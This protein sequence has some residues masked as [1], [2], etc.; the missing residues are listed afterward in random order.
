MGNTIFLDIETTGFKPEKGAE[1]L[2]FAG[3][4]CNTPN[5]YPFQ[6][7]QTMIFPENGINPAAFEVNKISYEMVKYACGIPEAIKDI[8]HF[9]K[10]DDILIGHNI[11]KFDIPFL[12]YFHGKKIENKLIDTLLL[13]KKLGF[14]R[15]CCA[16]VELADHF[17][18]SHNAH[19]AM[20]DVEVNWKI[21]KKLLEKEQG[22]LF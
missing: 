13:A 17:G 2:E 7:F 20:N 4:K 3:M 22:T 12:E 5:L 15:G 16:Q 10:P 18:I 11:V 19:R 1:A 8:F 14:K 6:K 21:Y 9:I